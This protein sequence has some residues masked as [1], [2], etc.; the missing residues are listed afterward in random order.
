MSS[1]NKLKSKS[2]VVLRKVPNVNMQVDKLGKPEMHQTGSNALTLRRQTRY[3]NW[4]NPVKRRSPSNKNKFLPEIKHDRKEKQK[5]QISPKKFDQYPVLS[6]VIPSPQIKSPKKQ[7]PT[8]RMDPAD[9]NLRRNNNE[10]SKV[11]LKASKSP[12]PKILVDVN[13]KFVET[14]RHH[15]SCSR[16]TKGSLSLEVR[17]K[18]DVVGTPFV[19]PKPIPTQTARERSQKVNPAMPMFGHTE[20]SMSKTKNFGKTRYEKEPIYERPDESLASQQPQHEKPVQPTPEQHHTISSPEIVPAMP[21]SI[22]TIVSNNSTQVGEVN[23]GTHI[24]FGKALPGTENY[25]KPEPPTNPPN[26]ANESEEEDY[27]A[28]FEPI[29]GKACM[30]LDSDVSVGSGPLVSR[31]NNYEH[32]NDQSMSERRDSATI[33]SNKEVLF[34]PK[35]GNKQMERT[36]W[37]KDQLD[38]LVENPNSFRQTRQNSNSEFFG[39][40]APDLSRRSLHNQSQAGFHKSNRDQREPTSEWVK[41]FIQTPEGSHS[42]KQLGGSRHKYLMKNIKAPSFSSRRE[43]QS[44]LLTLRLSSDRWGEGIQQGI[45]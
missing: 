9:R 22:K 4:D 25:S 26:I 27:S 35:K 12:Q 40:F 31:M 34:Q 23:T 21:D 41:S 19:V 37:P 20:S 38:R 42:P 7:A 10:I 29:D 1:P 30:L 3:L 15:R 39:E 2:G 24:T 13:K 16:P 28:P 32:L 36:P 45:V 33:D 14:L 8:I 43:E 6:K 11:P 44:S 18:L 17:C 5:E